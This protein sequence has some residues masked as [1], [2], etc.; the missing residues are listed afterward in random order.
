M[1]GQIAPTDLP[2]P[3]RGAAV[4]ANMPGKRKAKRKRPVPA[5][6][7]RARKKPVETGEDRTPN[8]SNTAAVDSDQ[9]KTPFT[10]EE[11]EF[12]D[13]LADDELASAQ[14]IYDRWV[15]RLVARHGIDARVD[16][17]RFDATVARY[18]ERLLRI[19]DAA[20]TMAESVSIDRAEIPKP[21][22]SDVRKTD[23]KELDE[24]TR[25]GFGGVCSGK[26]GSLLD[27]YGEI[28]WPPRMIVAVWALKGVIC[29]ISDPVC[30]SESIKDEATIVQQLNFAADLIRRTVVQCCSASEAESEPSRGQTDNRLVKSETGLTVKHEAKR[31]HWNGKAL[32]INR[33]ADFCV[34]VML[35]DRRGEIVEY[36]TLLRALKPASI[37]DNVSKVTEAP[38]EVKQAV[39]HIN[40]AIEKLDARIRIDN[41]RR[42]GYQLERRK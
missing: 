8:P 36:A 12:H 39:K 9:L 17:T 23:F 25:G 29:E 14:R 20:S 41:I 13:P 10:S 18:S 28:D 15:A 27:L 40:R 35:N 21:A 32:S 6:K 4:G 34:L 38:E 5:P 31:V 7:V 16:P 37:P 30:E 11:E 24:L 33:E 3:V 26:D 42:V 2:L 1:A 22:L 19:A